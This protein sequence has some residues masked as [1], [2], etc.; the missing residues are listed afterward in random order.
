[1]GTLYV[2]DEWTTQIRC[3]DGI[4]FI[5]AFNNKT[6]EKRRYKV[7]AATVRDLLDPTAIQNP[8]DIW[9]GEINRWVSK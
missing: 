5:L 8:Y 6:D 1:M 2:D 9:D 4:I 7:D 3:E